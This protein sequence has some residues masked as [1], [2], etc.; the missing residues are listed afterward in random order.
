MKRWLGLD[1][2]HV[3][4]GVALSDPLGVTAQPLT[5][6]RS[7]GTQKDI[8]AIGEL[9]DQHEVTQVVVGLPLNMDG[10]ESSTTKKVR[11][12][13][14][15]LAERLN[16]PVFFVDER[17]TSKQAE[18]LMIEGDSRREDR[19]QKVDKVAAA[20]LLQSALKGAAL[21]PV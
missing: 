21:I 13:T 17:L 2:G 14:G 20:L 18:R 16:V 4:I 3:R 5:V 10:T 6:L 9:V 1:L 8:I 12:F 15:K 11:E 7:S 19:R